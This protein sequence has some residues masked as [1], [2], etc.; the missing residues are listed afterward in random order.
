MDISRP[1]AC[2]LC[3]QVA[4]AKTNFVLAGQVEVP[5]APPLKKTD[6]SVFFNFVRARVFL[7]FNHTHNYSIKWSSY[8]YGLAPLFLTPRKEF[9]L[10]PL[11]RLGFIPTNVKK[12]PTVTF[13]HSCAPTRD[14]CL[15]F[16]FL[17]SNVHAAISA[18]T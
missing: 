8:V 1:L 4:S 15:F 12:P 16:W 10:G 14:G 18:R 3:L 9:S 13:L 11:C 7:G 5:V 2:K 17:F 6:F